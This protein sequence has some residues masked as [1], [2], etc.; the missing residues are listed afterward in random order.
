MEF[1]TEY[2][3]QIRIVRL[4]GSVDSVSTPIV[5]S[6]IDPF[7]KKGEE[8]FLLSF[9]NVTYMSSAGLRFLLVTEKKL[10][11]LLGK[12]KICQLNEHVLEVI[13]IS[14]FDK[15]LHIYE[16]EEDAFKDF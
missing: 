3:D 7:I 6:M 5:E 9:E 10:R 14:G 16:T 8:K 12:L 2:R 4:G 11:Q 15:Y 1:T 13:H